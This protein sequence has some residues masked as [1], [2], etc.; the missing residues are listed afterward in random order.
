MM[1]SVAPFSSIQQILQTGEKPAGCL[2]DTN[3]LIA[4]IYDVHRFNGEAV[5]LFDVL[6]DAAIPLYVSL[7]TRSEF[8]DIQRRI[9]M[10][11]ALMEMASDKTKWRISAEVLKELR[12]QK[13]WIG[14]QAEKDEMPI[15]TDARIKACKQLF[16]PK[17]QSGKSGWLELCRHFLS[18]LLST[19][20]QAV[21]NMGIRYIG[22]RETE[23]LQLFS[24]KLHWEKMYALSVK[25]ALSSMDAMILN[26][27]NSSAFP[28]LVSTDYDLAY[29]VLAE[30]NTKTILVPDSLYERKIKGLRFPSSANG[31]PRWS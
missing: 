30:D 16:L 10:T 22:A 15:L 2:L 18:P 12:N 11:E 17:N 1:G 28:L 21:A 4:A 25:T 5:A 6:A 26:V 20:D 13:R 27:F 31:T 29:A 8:L 19:W 24:T 9:I 7:P 23:E 3:F 14:I